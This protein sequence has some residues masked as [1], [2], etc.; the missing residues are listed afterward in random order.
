MILGV[1]M[2]VVEVPRMQRILK[3]AWANRFLERVFSP[4][5]IAVCERSAVP[6]Q[7]YAARFAAKEAVAKALGRWLR[8]H[9][10]EVVND[11]RGRPSVALSGEAAELARV[12]EGGHLLVSLSHSRDY[13]V[14]A[15]VLVLPQGIP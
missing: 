8:W 7:G 10:V 2:D 1:G 15:V 11:D 12:P 3:S 9:E 14:A 6:A 5:E 4:E 13:A